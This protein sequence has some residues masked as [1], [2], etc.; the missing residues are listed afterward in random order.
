MIVKRKPSF[1]LDANMSPETANF[2]RSLGFDAKSLI[3]EKLGGI[4][5][6]AV[7]KI[8]EKEQRILITFDLDFGELYYFSSKKKLGIIILRLKDQ[9]PEAVN[10]IL[11]LFLKSQKIVFEKGV[12][13]L[14]ILSE[15]ELRVADY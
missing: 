13:R 9:R 8:A 6:A 11:G 10:I 14:V 15:N 1:L 4:E 7:A 12:R 3:E 2:L 5:D